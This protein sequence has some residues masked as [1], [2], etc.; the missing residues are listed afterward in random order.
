[1]IT[2]IYTHTYIMQLNKHQYSS[3]T[4]VHA[5]ATLTH[6]CNIHIGITHQL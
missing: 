2:H 1:M 6:T 3:H 4:P 5:E